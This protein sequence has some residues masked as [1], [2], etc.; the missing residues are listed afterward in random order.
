MTRSL[1]A[2]VVIAVLVLPLTILLLLDPS[3]QAACTTGSTGGGGPSAVPGIPVA[4]LPIFE[5]A[6]TQFNLGPD[7]FA[8]LAA[9][10]YDESSFDTSNLPGVHSGANYDGAAGPM[11]LGIGGKAGP[12][13][14]SYEPQIP[15]DVAGGA[16]PPSVYNEADAVYAGAAKLAADGAPGDWQAAITAWNDYAPE[17]ATVN[18]LVAQYTGITPTSTATGTSTSTT[19]TAAPTTTT[20]PSSSAGCSAA[21]SGPS[22]PGASSM[23]GSN[24]VA[25]IPQGAPAAVQQMLSAGNELIDYD[26]SYGGGYC[27]AA[28]NVPPGPASCPGQQENGA[29]GYDCASAVSFL[30][31][32]GG[33]AENVLDGAAEDS[34]SLEDA[35]LSGPGKYVTIYAG[36]SGGDPHAFI[37]VDGVVMDTVHGQPTTPGGTGPRWQSIAEVQYELNSGSFVERHPPGL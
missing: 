17:I 16:D 3:S 6:S 28:E 20:S 12:T 35:G 24:G 4:D 27:N 15:A 21:T 1:V 23:V 5:A 13:W 26:Y 34:E 7:G 22:V 25:A 30:L 37:E 19:S 33:F 9:L 8:Y 31:W 18:M 14:Q 36:E 11:Q 10:N 2:F 29:P 32:N